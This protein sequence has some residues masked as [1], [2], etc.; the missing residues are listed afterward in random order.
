MGLL[1]PLIT[2][3]SLLKHNLVTHVKFT[4]GIVDASWLEASLLSTLF[5][6]KL[7]PYISYY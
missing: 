1:L 4:I 7:M 3:L 5:W 6:D 2:G